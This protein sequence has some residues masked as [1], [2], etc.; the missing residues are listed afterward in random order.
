MMRLLSLL[1][2]SGLAFP[3]LAQSPAGAWRVV[4]RTGLEATGLVTTEAGVTQGHGRNRLRQP[5]PAG[6]EK[7]LRRKAGAPCRLDMRLRLS[8][9]QEAVLRDQDVCAS[10]TAIFEATAIQPAEPAPRRERRPRAG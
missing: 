10:P 2:L 8:G 5:L 6:A 3:A 4:N 7:T 1:L 9:G